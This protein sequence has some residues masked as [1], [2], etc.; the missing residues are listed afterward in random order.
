MYKELKDNQKDVLKALLL[1]PILVENGY[2]YKAS[3][4]EHENDLIYKNDNWFCYTNNSS[5]QSDNGKKIYIVSKQK[6]CGTKDADMSDIAVAFYESLYEISML[7]NDKNDF[8]NP[9]FAG[10]T[11][12][13]LAPFYNNKKEVFRKEMLDVYKNIKN[14]EEN[15]KNQEENIKSKINEFSGKYHCLAN[16]W[17]LPKGVGREIEDF[18]KGRDSTYCD[19]MD[20]FLIGIMRKTN[21]QSDKNN[22]YN[23]QN[24][25]TEKYPEYCNK[26]KKNN[27]ETTPFDW[28]IFASRHFING[29]YLLKQNG[30]FYVASYSN[31]TDPIQTI[32]SMDTLIEMRADAIMRSKL[33][34]RLYNKLT[35]Q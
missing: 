19:F 3:L 26:F 22:R 11:M 23:Q 5:E 18:G 9:A 7:D 6:Y 25:F 21:I 12:N 10:D 24:T 16:F 27:S 4:K 13:S 32:N 28:D 17:V 2:K 20:N 31:L 35:G 14:Q 29:I 1:A 15:I 30:F 33:A 8:R 34:Y